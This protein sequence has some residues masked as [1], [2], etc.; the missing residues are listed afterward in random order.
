MFVKLIFTVLLTFDTYVSAAVVWK[1][2][3]G[4]TAAELAGSEPPLSIDIDKTSVHYDANTSFLV[5]SCDRHEGTCDA[6]CCCDLDCKYVSSISQN[7]FLP[8]EFEYI[9]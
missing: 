3:Y 4:P 7:S 9:F 5:C 2:E 8:R 1:K 6:F